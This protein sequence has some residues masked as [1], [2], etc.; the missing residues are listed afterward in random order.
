MDLATEMAKTI[1]DQ[2]IKINTK[3]VFDIREEISILFKT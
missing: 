3:K 2:P 1:M